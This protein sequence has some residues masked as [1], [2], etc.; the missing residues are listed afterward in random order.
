MFVLQNTPDA[1]E[2][3]LGDLTLCTEN[4][5]LPVAKF[6][7]TFTVEE[8]KDGLSLAIEYCTDLF[9][10][11]TIAR[12]AGHYEQLLR[13]IVLESSAQVSVLP[14]L[15]N[16]EADQLLLQLSGEQTIYPDYSNVI[17][18]FEEWVVKTPDATALVFEDQQYTYQE[19][20]E[21]ANRLAYYLI[22]QG[23]KADDLVG[24]CI[25]RSLDMIAGILG[26]WKAGG[27]Y[28]PIDPSYPQDRVDYIIE[29]SGI[30]L[31]VSDQ[32]SRSA[33]PE[34]MQVILL[35]ETEFLAQQPVYSPTNSIAS[36]DLSYVIYTSGSTGKPKGVLVEHRGML[37]HLYAKINSLKMDEQSIVAYIASYTFDISVWQMFCAL[38]TGGQTVIYPYDLI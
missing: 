7:I 1:P 37:N 27:A 23:I 12:M 30:S 18:L 6:D 32:Q 10:E 8:G 15:T 24:I 22:G 14:M 21:K 31:M 38:L 13:S 35:D 20:N 26:I 34:K 29:D 5:H 17:A 33:L 9:R 2:L 25:G 28:V 16:G 36:Q 19:L 11:D 3:V 4:I